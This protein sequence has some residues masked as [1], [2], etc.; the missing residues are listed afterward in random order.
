MTRAAIMH[1][2]L[3]EVGYNLYLLSPL[4]SSGSLSALSPLPEPLQSWPSNVD[5]LASQCMAHARALT[6]LSRD[7][8]AYVMSVTHLLHTPGLIFRLD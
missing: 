5:V 4:H 7:I 2:L 1:S 3:G 6:I 8:S